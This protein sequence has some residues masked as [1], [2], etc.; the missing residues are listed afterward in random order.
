[1]CDAFW[2]WSGRPS[3]IYLGHTNRIIS[4]HQPSENSATGE[5]TAQQQTTRMQQGIPSLEGN[6]THH[7]LLEQLH[8]AHTG[9]YSAAKTARWVIII[10]EEGTA[11]MHQ[12]EKICKK[13]KCCCIP[14]SP[15]ESI[16][17]RRIQ[18]YYSLLWYHKGKI[19]SLGNLKQA[20][21]C[22]NILNPLSLSIQEI[23]VHLEACRKE[24]A[25]YQEHG[26]RF[27]R[28]HLENRKRIA[29]KQEDK[30]AFQKISAIIQR[31]Q[32]QFF[33]KSSIT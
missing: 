13:V 33:G 1:M 10:E 32:Q 28:R 29:L 21:R 19:K 6:I 20:A 11:Y 17:I 3:R 4:R 23:T 7:R 24:Y 8:E 12:A 2:V 22:C 14:F 27:R 9:G 5:S 18:V 16:W 26:K 25:F 31:E 30:E 15:E